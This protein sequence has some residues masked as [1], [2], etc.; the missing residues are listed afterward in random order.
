MRCS[1]ASAAACSIVREIH[2]FSNEPLR[3]RASLRWDIGR[4]WAEVRRGLDAGSGRAA[5]EHRRRHLGLRLTRSSTSGRPGREPVSLSRH[6]HRR[7]HGGGLRARA[8]RRDLRDHRHPVPAVQHAVSS[9]TPHAAATPTADR[10]GARA[11]D[12]PRPLQL[13]AD[14]RARRRVH[15]TRRPRSS[16]TRERDRGRPDCC[17]RSIFRRGCCRR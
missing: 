12:H 8:G 7:R 13:L 3:D 4:L 5:G 17:R 14:R 10:C 9:S 16:S 6:A 2:R 1:A 11:R 15:R